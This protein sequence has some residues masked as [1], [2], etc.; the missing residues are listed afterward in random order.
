MGNYLNNLTSKTINGKF[1]YELYDDKI[2]IKDDYID[3]DFTIFYFDEYIKSKCCQV[4]SKARTDK[5]FITFLH[6]NSTIY[7]LY[8]NKILFPSN[9]IKPTSYGWFYIF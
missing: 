5:S 6:H 9:K 1:I 4:F 2:I 7:A 8:D 3:N